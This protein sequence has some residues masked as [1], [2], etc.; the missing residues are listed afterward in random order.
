MIIIIINQ[1]NVHQNFLKVYFSLEVFR[2]LSFKSSYFPM[3]GHVCKNNFYFLTFSEY[4]FSQG[5]NL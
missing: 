5:I 3:S 2:K 1:A 4:V